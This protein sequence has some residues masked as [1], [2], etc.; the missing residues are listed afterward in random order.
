MAMH[1]AGVKLHRGHG[2]AQPRKSRLL[3]RLVR[4]THN[5]YLAGVAQP[6]PEAAAKELKRL[7]DSGEL[8]KRSMGLRK[9]G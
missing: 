7:K 3:A 8:P 6:W 2:P 4:R 5:P 1:T 9:T